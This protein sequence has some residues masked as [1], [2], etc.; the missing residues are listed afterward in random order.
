[1]IQKLRNKLSR[2]A[3]VDLT[4]ITH[5]EYDPAWSC[6]LGGCLR[7]WQVPEVL[8]LLISH[9]WFYSFTAAFYTA[10]WFLTSAKYIPFN[11]ICLTTY[12]YPSI[13]T[14]NI[15]QIQ[16]NEFTQILLILEI[17]SICYTKRVRSSCNFVNGNFVCVCVCVE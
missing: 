10:I 3:Q 12:I 17:Y 2:T 9:T 14:W 1:M 11:L 7:W 4:L 16:E 6:W 13:D 8:H 15:F 5:N